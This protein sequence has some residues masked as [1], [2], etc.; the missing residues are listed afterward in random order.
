MLATLECF[1]DA[2]PVR[3]SNDARHAIELGRLR[4]PLPSHDGAS[5][6][7]RTLYC[8]YNYNY[9]PKYPEV[10]FFIPS[11]RREERYEDCNGL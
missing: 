6:C 4:K 7:P 3:A 11:V 5:I 2:A 9:K 1:T 10:A 8:Y